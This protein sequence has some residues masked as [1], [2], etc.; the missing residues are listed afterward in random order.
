SGIAFTSG[1]YPDDSTHVELVRYGAGSDM[2]CGISTLLVGGGP[3]PVRM[4]KYTWQVLRHP[5]DFM[6]SLRFKHWAKR[7][8]I[9]LVM[10]NRDNHMRLV[11]KRRWYW[12]F[13]KRLTTEVKAEHAVPVHMPMAN[14]VAERMAKKIGGYPVGSLPEVL[15]NRATTAHILG[16]AVIGATAS[17]GVIDMYNQVFAY[18]GL[19]VVDGS[20]I[21][22]NLGV[23]P[24]L[25]ITAMAERAMSYIPEKHPQSSDQLERQEAFALL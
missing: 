21:P 6:R 5:L 20:M 19:Y 2:I 22:A 14:E 11:W 8:M 3:T 25:T 12:P 1:F 17:E 15:F 13:S 4:L 10:Q 18:P 9:L 7:N 16:G 23:N 24:S